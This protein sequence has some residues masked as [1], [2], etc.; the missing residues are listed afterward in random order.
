M[1]RRAALRALAW[2]LAAS[3]GLA[4]SQGTR[5][6][7]VVMI[8]ATAEDEA[9]PFVESFRGGLRD[10]GHVE[11]KTLALEVRYGRLERG[12]IE[13]LEREAIAEG[14]DVLVIAGL[15]SAR[16]VRDLTSTIPV[17]VATAS[18][19]VDAGVV[20]SF[21]RPGGNITGISD[22]VDEAAVKR[23]ELT[24]AALPNAKRV[25]LITNPD[26]PATPKIE[27]RVAEAAPRLGLAVTRLRAT[28][29]ASLAAAIDS[30]AQA[31][32]DALLV[33]GDPLFNPGEFIERA[34]AL[35]VPVIHY[36][37]GTAMQGALVSHEADIHDNFRRA[38]G[39]VDRILKGAK[40][41]DLPIHQPTRYKLV[42]NLKTAKALGL[43]IPQAML[44]R[45]DE[46]IR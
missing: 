4:A 46:V 38:A 30:M 7:R 15:S 8:V 29:P 20:K 23:L 35:R 11:G 44:Q 14:P 19:L 21:A 32:P 37:P 25:V 3:P 18:N 1:R 9:R 16:R 6:L 22:L 34:N 28:D 24:R 39:Y 10:A 40:P 31:P 27:S 13:S 41:A 17:V 12:R 45:A 2:V 42:V 26:F 33:G 5:L 43:D 36:W